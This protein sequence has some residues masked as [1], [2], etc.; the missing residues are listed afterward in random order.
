MMR[1]ISGAS[2]IRLPPRVKY[3]S[4]NIFRKARCVVIGEAPVKPSLKPTSDAQRERAKGQA[5]RL[6]D[7]DWAAKQNALK[8]EFTFHL[9][10]LTFRVAPQ[11]SLTIRFRESLHLLAPTRRP[12]NNSKA[13]NAACSPWTMGCVFTVVRGGWE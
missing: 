4:C 8:A 12:S 1:Q 13:A 11:D 2:T 9:S 3:Q 7:N 6:F 10:L 5:F